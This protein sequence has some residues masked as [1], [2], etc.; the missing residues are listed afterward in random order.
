M[1]TH[2]FGVITRFMTAYGNAMNHAEYF[3]TKIE[4]S[5]SNVTSSASLHYQNKD[6]GPLSQNGVVLAGFEELVL[7]NYKS[8]D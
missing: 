6:G 3:R 2:P 7:E 4:E 8:L 1:K 5:F